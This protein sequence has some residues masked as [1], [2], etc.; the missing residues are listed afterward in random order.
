MLYGNRSIQKRS[1]LNYLQSIQAM[2]KPRISKSETREEINSQVEDF[3]K[4]K[5]TITQ[6]KMGDSGLVDG[7]YNTSHIGFGEPKKP[8]T[9]LNYVVATL[10]QRK[11]KKT[12]TTAFVKHKKPTKKVIYDD[13]GEPLRWVW[14]D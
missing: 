12:P 6:A 4:S 9:P 2:I 7:K 8:R 14:E 10:Q 5:G 13:F 3:L 11:T 1:S